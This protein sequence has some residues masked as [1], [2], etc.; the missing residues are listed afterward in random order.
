M[1]LNGFNINVHRFTALQPLGWLRWSARCPAWRWPFSGPRSLQGSIW[2]LCSA[3]SWCRHAS[4]GSRSGAL[5][6]MIQCYF[7]WAATATVT[8]PSTRPHYRTVH[9]PGGECPHWT[10]PAAFRCCWW[11][12]NPHAARK[13]CPYRRD[14]GHDA[15][16]SSRCRW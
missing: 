7:R 5:L 15:L 3:Q 14:P 8:K 12:P 1:Y 10:K 2:C 6:A 16:R 13:I 4:A 11:H 9:F